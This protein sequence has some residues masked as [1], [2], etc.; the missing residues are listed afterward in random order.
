[1]I[2]NP[3]TDNLTAIFEAKLKAVINNQGPQES[4]ILKCCFQL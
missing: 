3:W 1:M 4:P 2:S